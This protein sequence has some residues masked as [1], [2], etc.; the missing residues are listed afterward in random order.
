MP[1]DPIMSSS[2]IDRWE[3]LLA[4]LVALVP[5]MFRPRTPNTRRWAARIDACVRASAEHAHRDEHRAHHD[6]HVP[7]RAV[8]PPGVAEHVDGMLA[9]SDGPA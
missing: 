7:V 3:A 9:W 1:T 2:P 5:A 6:E 4:D 8:P